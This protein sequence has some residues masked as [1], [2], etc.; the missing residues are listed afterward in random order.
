MRYYS[1]TLML[2]KYTSNEKEPIYMEAYTIPSDYKELHDIMEKFGK[3]HV[4]DLIPHGLKK[5]I[6]NH[7]RWVLTDFAVSHYRLPE[8]PIMEYVMIAAS[9]EERITRGNALDI[10]AFYRILA[11]RNILKLLARAHEFHD[12]VKRYYELSIGQ[13]LAPVESSDY[14]AKSNLSE[15]LQRFSLSSDDSIRKMAD[16]IL[17]HIEPITAHCNDKNTICEKLAGGTNKEQ[18]ILFAYELYH[19]VFPLYYSLCFPVTYSEE[20]MNLK[21]H[22]N[23]FWDDYDDKFIHAVRTWYEGGDDCE[24]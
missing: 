14:M 1:M 9:L 20:H 19:L 3:A 2:K 10:T 16:T 11:A 4:E 7:L 24:D 22:T 5:I 18:D 21:Y 17:V 8:M 15:L 13:V 23:K 6:L 12:D